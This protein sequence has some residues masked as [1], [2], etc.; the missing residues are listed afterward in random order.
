MVAGSRDSALVDAHVHVWDPA[1]LSYPWLDGV[2]AIDRAFL[3][4]DIDRAAGAVTGH[5]FV[6][7]GCLPEQALD[8]VRWVLGMTDAW[9]ELAAIVADADLRGG[10]ALASHLNELLNL[11]TERVR[12]V[13]VRHLL[14][15]ERD[16]LLA[17]PA[18]R[19]ALL[20][21]LRTLA[22]Y[23]LTF[24]V[25]VRHRQ[26][27]T[28]TEVLEQVPELPTVL[29]HL[30]KPPLDAGIAS[31]A[32]RAWAGALARLARLP[33][34]HVKLSGLAAEA[35][36]TDALDAHAQDFLV[37]A[38][39]TFGPDRSMIGSDWPV[40]AFTGAGGTFDG[41]RGR[42]RRAAT[43]AGVHAE[44]AASIEHRTATRFYGLGG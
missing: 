15:D 23:G 14:Q 39:R 7:A 36:G 42:V 10:A 26:L 22:A 30:G 8:E 17:D 18:A 33:H 25:C 13:G 19:S 24:D 44:G 21:G 31:E 11:N 16:D 6:Q 29:D 37:H 28:V 9:S 43:A 34:A 32:G 38:L 20:D 27:D 41:W 35:S 1:R 5:V 4:D 12:V 3:L 40:S 2:P